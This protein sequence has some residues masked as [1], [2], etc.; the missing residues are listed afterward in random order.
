[1][2]RRIAK[3]SLQQALQFFLGAGRFA[4]SQP[5]KFGLRL[6]RAAS[7][8]AGVKN[9]ENTFLKSRKEKQRRGDLS[10]IQL[11]SLDQ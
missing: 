3:A 2:Q 8:D 10:V 4:L 1:M 7:V 11:C 5:L 6:Q 9:Y